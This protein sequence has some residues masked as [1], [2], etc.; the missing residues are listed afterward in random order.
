MNSNEAKQTGAERMKKTGE[1]L[2]AGLERM[3]ELYREAVV[4]VPAQMPEVT[5]IFLG[6]CVK[7]GVGSSFRHQA[8]AHNT[9]PDSRYGWICVRS[10]KR[11]GDYDALRA[12]SGKTVI[13]IHQ[14]SRLLMHE[15]AHI[16]C[17]GHGHDDK[18]R[19]QMADLGQPLPKHYQKRTRAL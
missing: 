16:L 8:H 12:D 2:R 10:I 4:E 7:R 9:Q 18:W 6:G 3:R 14:A 19:R 15:Y 17:P 5:G 11:I 13:T 1:E